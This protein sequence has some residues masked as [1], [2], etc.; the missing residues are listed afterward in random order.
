MGYYDFKRNMESAMETSVTFTQKNVFKQLC[1]Y[2]EMVSQKPFILMQLRQS[3]D[4]KSNNFYNNSKNII[5]NSYSFLS[6]TGNGYADINYKQPN[7]NLIFEQ[8]LCEACQQ[9]SKPW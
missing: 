8:L 4:N 5:I 7:V 9:H 6:L 1:H 3:H 2:K